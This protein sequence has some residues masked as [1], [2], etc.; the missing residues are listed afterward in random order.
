MRTCAPN[1]IVIK[2]GGDEATFDRLV[3]PESMVGPK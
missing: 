2:A 1:A 3:R